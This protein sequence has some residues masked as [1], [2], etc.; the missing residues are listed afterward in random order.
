MSGFFAPQLLDTVRV[1]GLRG[2]RV[3][4]PPLGYISNAFLGLWLETAFGSRLMSIAT[5]PSSTT[6][7]ISIDIK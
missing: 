3:R 6:A 4:N 2:I 7:K 5:F 1:V